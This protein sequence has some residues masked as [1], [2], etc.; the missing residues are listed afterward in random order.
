MPK[1]R[2]ILA[3]DHAI[4]REGLALLLAPEVELVATVANGHD[5]VGAARTLQPDLIVADLTMP[6]LGGIEALRTLRAEGAGTRFIVLTVH[7]DASI[8]AE[9]I[10]AG[11]RAVC[12]G[13]AIT[14]PIAVTRGFAESVG[15]A[16]SAPR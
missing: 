3:D 12:V 6:G 5:L 9:A 16:Y 14:E 8:A 13:T 11:A 7:V 15:A 2:V 4:V 1:P 10:R